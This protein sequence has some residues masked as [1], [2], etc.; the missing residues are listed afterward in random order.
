MNREEPVMLA[1]LPAGHRAAFAAACAESLLPNYAAF[2]AET[3]WGDAAEL[4]YALDFVWRHLAGA[5]SLD[6]QTV[7]ELTGHVEDVLPDTEDFQ[8]PSAGRALDAGIAVI[9]ALAACVDPDPEHAHTAATMTTDTADAYVCDLLDLSGN[10]PDLEERIAA[11]PLMQNQL[12][13]HQ[14]LIDEL[15]RHRRLTPELLDAIRARAWNGGVS[16]IGLKGCC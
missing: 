14:A 1:D 9:E 7:E 11:H 16:N 15:G 13:R 2:A 5:V 10:E 4:R 3:E 12:Q 6:A 8:T